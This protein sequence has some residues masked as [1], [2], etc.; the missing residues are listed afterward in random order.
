MLYTKMFHMLLS[1][2]NGL[3]RTY[4]LAAKASN[5]GVGIHLGKVVTHG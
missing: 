3:L 5:A 1:Q 4:F 2:S